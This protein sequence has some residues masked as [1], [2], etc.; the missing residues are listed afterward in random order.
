MI[1]KGP[2]T[3]CR[4]SRD[5]RRDHEHPVAGFALTEAIFFYA[6]VSGLLAF[7]L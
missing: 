3:P 6:Q 1:F 4:A 2:S 7:V 5:A